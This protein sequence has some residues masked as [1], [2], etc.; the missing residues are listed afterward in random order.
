MGLRF[1]E[2]LGLMGDEDNELFARATQA[3]FE[4]RRTDKAV[5]TEVGHPERL[6]YRGHMYRAYWCAASDMRRTA[7]RNGWPGAVARKAHP[8]PLNM[9]FG[10]L[11]LLTSPVCIIGGLDAFK[12]RALAGGKKIAKGAGRAAAMI[13]R[14]TQPYANVFV[15]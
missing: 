3:G 5:V 1:D 15:H 7:I 13:R 11:E 8:V 12:R 10:A 9:I 6:T 14:L 4:I 2:G